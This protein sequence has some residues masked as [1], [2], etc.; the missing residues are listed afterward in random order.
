MGSLVQ[1][2]LLLVATLLVYGQPPTL[3]EYQVAQLAHRMEAIEALQE[4][5]VLLLVA[6]LLAVVVSLVTYLLTRRT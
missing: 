1:V 5:L 6:N 3:L 2:V 4:R